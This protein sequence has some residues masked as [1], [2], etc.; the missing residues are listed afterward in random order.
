[1]GIQK[2]HR[3]RWGL[4]IRLVDKPAAF[5]CCPA[6]L[7]FPGCP[8]SCKA[9]LFTHLL[10]QPFV[11]I[12]SLRRPTSPLDISPSRVPEFQCPTRVIGIP[13][14]G[15]PPFE[16][17]FFWY[18]KRVTLTAC[19][20]FVRKPWPVERIWTSSHLS[21]GLYP[22][23]VYPATATVFDA[24]PIAWFLAGIEPALIP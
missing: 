4:G 14:Q 2:P 11:G 9:N 6:Q 7:P 8:C 3:L 16:G 17:S 22:G 12:L 20:F 23:F 10:T 18:R 1:M 24:L 15:S 5:F 13:L 19:S 21:P